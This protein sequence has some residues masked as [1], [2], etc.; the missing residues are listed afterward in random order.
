MNV[1]M[2]P[3][4]YIEH[5]RAKSLLKDGD[6]RRLSYFFT[7]SHNPQSPL[8]HPLLTPRRSSSP[9]LPLLLFIAV[10]SCAC[11]FLLLLLLLLLTTLYNIFSPAFFMHFHL[12]FAFF[13]ISY[14]SLSSVRLKTML[15]FLFESFSLFFLPFCIFFHF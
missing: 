15:I 13:S 10:Y 2:C 11:R 7:V 3:V 5:C 9:L 12:V 1:Y 14:I 8:S 6:H 4:K